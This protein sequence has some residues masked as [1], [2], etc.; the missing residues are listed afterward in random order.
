MIEKYS[1]GEFI[2]ET[3]TNVITLND[4]LY[5]WKAMAKKMSI[6][7]FCKLNSVIRK[8]MHDTPFAPATMPYGSFGNVWERSRLC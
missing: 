8:H 6:Y 4:T 5:N 3:V 1:G 7:T 2:T